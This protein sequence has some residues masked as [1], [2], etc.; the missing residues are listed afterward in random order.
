MQPI[1]Y[2]AAVIRIKLK[3]L[4]AKR[5]FQENR[6][7]TLNEV[8]EVT[9]IHRVTLSKIA[10]ERGYNA[11]LDNVDRLCNYFGCQ[12]GDLLE[13]VPDDTIKER[14]QTANRARK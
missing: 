9:A 5:E 1:R 7:I 3:E 13:F 11:G 8:G 14:T 4:I 2:G 12:P 6:R 10:N